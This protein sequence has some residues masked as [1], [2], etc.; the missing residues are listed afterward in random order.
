MS[1]I[2]VK[3]KIVWISQI[4]YKNKQKNMKMKDEEINKNIPIIFQKHIEVDF[5]TIY[6]YFCIRFSF[7]VRSDQC[8]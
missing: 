2:Q 8:E 4:C 5:Y 3:I 7:G 6:I 1:K